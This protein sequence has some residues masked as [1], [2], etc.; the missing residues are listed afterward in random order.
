[1]TIKRSTKVTFIKIK[2]LFN[3]HDLDVDKI[4][5]S[6]KESHGTK[7]SFKY[8]TGYNDDDVFRPLCIKLPQMI[9]Y[10][11]HFDSNKTMYFKFGDNKLLKKYN[12]IWEKI[13]NLMNIEFDS[14]PVYG[15]NDKY[16]K[17]N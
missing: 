5:V 4:L 6:T 15:D 12:K 9:G 8:F 11:K 7:N 16:I 17:K 10:V 2:K 1:M 13:S 14:D 3:L